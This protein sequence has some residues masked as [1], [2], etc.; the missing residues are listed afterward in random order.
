[1]CQNR[2][3]SVYQK[4]LPREVRLAPI[5]QARGVAASLDLATETLGDLTAS[6]LLLGEG[7]S[8]LPP[9]CTATTSMLTMLSRNM[10]TLRICLGL[11]DCLR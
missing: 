2:Y 7:G 8:L 3:C 1:M 5:S 6:V 4:S 11:M 9:N 10:S